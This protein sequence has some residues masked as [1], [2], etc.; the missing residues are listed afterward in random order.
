MLLAV[1]N[2]NA[3]DMFEVLF[4]HQKTRPTTTYLSHHSVVSKCKISVLM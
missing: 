1:G 3:K 2:K 4:I